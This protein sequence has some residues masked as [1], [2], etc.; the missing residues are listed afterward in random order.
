MTNPSEETIMSINEEYS[1]LLNTGLMNLMGAPGMVVIM[2]M[3]R[4]NI[5]G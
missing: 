1:A 5:Q 4:G 2:I 3:F